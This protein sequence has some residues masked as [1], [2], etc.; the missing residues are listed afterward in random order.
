MA[1][2]W[3]GASKAAM[4][5]MMAAGLAFASGCSLRS[6]NQPAQA[7]VVTPAKAEAKPAAKAKAEAPKSARDLMVEQ[8]AALGYRLEWI[9]YATV[10]PGA[11][12][13]HAE[14]LGDVLAVQDTR[15]ALT[16]VQTRDA[17]A[18]WSQIV[19]DEFVNTFALVRMGPTLVACGESELYLIDADSGNL[20]GKQR[21]ERVVNTAP[22]Q[23]DNLLVFGTAQGAAIAHHVGAGRTAWLYSIDGPVNIDPIAVG[24]GAVGVVASSGQVLIMDARGGVQL[25]RA[26]M[27]D[28]AGAGLGAGS[29]TLYVASLDQSLY[30]FARD[31]GFTRWRVRTEQP[32][33]GQPVLTGSRLIV[34]MPEGVQALS[35]AT[36]K[37]EW[38]NTDLKSGKLIGIRNGRG[39]WWDGAAL[40]TLELDT[41]KVVASM[42]MPGISLVTTDQ[43]TDGRLYLVTDKGAITK[44]SPR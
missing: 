44:L 35:A 28:N 43:F 11:K 2:A 29:D 20:V 16:A 33:R 4:A 34:A 6:G 9:G 38:T 41:G 27:F 3:T 21:L 24:E 5:A 7:A 10:L 30:A 13:R 40:R 12:V 42:D 39:L 37:A 1:I 26:R 14:V 17:T 31:G 23:V 36:G 15:N 32:L 19:G 8:Y 25:G 18:R 22:V